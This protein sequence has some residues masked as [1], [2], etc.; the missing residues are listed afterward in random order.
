MKEKQF[1]LIIAIDI[2]SLN[3]EPKK[4]IFATG[5]LDIIDAETLKYKGEEEFFLKH[6]QQI[7]RQ[8]AAEY[9]RTRIS[10]PV[11]ISLN[12]EGIFLSDGE[13]KIRPLFENISFKEKKIPLKDIVIDKM[14]KGML[15]IWYQVD[16]KRE[17]EDEDFESFFT[18]LPRYL[19]E[20]LE[21]ERATLIDMEFLWSELDGIKKYGSIIRFLLL[22][23]NLP[24]EELYTRY[25]ETVNLQ[26][27]VTKER[28][29]Y[30]GFAVRLPYKE[31]N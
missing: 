28:S 30:R 25:C 7:K 21:L 12:A 13:H 1:N 8:I 20:N 24:F 18:D 17:K 19:L 26:K 9:E 16:K 22:G 31:D 14:Q 15:N 29:S 23:P 2:H 5:S 6:K 11:D 3:P 10:P 27:I 4:Y